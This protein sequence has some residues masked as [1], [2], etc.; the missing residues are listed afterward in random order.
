MAAPGIARRDRIA[1]VLLVLLITGIG[2]ALAARRAILDDGTEPAPDARQQ[3]D[4]VLFDRFAAR[5]ERSEEGERLSVSLRLRTSA[6]VSLPCYVFV[7]ARAEQA[8]PRLWAAWPPEAEGAAISTGGHFHGARPDAG[9]ALTLSDA[10]QRITAT[11][12]EPARADFDTVIVYV[13]DPAG[14]ILLAR[15]F[16]V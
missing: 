11:V 8:T 12:P 2:G 15:P 4:A 13:V 6:S 1:A 7:V 10:W 14:R 9:F 3:R 5:R 16:K